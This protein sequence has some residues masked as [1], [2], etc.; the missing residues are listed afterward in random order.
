[1]YLKEIRISGFKSFADKISL[2]MDDNITCI[3]GP[4]GSGK[5]NIV[6]AVKW[7]LGEQSVKTLRGSNNMT[8]VIFAGSKSRNPLNL[9]SVSLVFDNS[10]SYLKVGFSE[11]AITRKVYRTGENEYFINNDKCRFKDITD[12]FLD[13]GMGKYAFNIISQGEVSKIISDSPFDRR[14]LFE[15]AAEVLKYKK[16]KEEALRK[17]DKTNE[18]LVRVTDIISELEGQI[19]PL[20]EQSVKAKRYLEVKDNLENIEIALMATEI[21]KLNSSYQEGLKQV[22]DIQNRIVLEST[23]NT[24]NDLKI[25]DVKKQL[26][27]IDLKIAELNQVYVALIKEEEKINGEKN[28]LKERSKYTSSDIKIHE[29]ISRLKEDSFAFNNKV[30]SL[31][32]DINILKDKFADICSKITDL[33]SNLVIFAKKNDTINSEIVVKKKEL[34]VGEYRLKSLMDYVYSNQSGNQTVNSILNNPKL[35]GVH[36]T[37]GKIVDVEDK[38][39]QAVSVAMGASKDFLVVDSPEVAKRCI[40][41]LK[42]NKLGRVTFFPLNVIKPRNVDDM[43]LNMLEKCEGYINVL[44]KLIICESIYSNIIQNQFGNVILVDNLEHANEISKIINQRYRIVTLAGDIIHVG[45]SITGGNL[46]TSSIINEKHELIESDIP[47]SYMDLQEAYEDL[48]HDKKSTELF[49]NI[50]KNRTRKMLWYEYTKENHMVE[51]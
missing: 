25:D 2:N 10:D 15:E 37:I 12:L 20:K 43:T 18:N 13:S 32:S 17:L 35:K 19:E 23:S 45:G 5:S 8:D 36:K 41:Y 48:L 9:A 39:I 40:D 51:Y 24:N 34:V 30:L 14:V 29:N 33:N 4:N 22:T 38:Y 1:M 11:I 42:D 49:Q 7:V 31:Q 27:E 28:I 44:D 50:E 3:V 6:D 16:R 47:V 21:E 46:K 26:S